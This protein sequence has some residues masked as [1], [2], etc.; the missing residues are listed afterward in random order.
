[1]KLENETIERA[2]QQRRLDLRRSPRHSVRIRALLHHAGR[3]QTTIIND[4]SVHGARVDGAIGV[5][6]G[7]VVELG[8]MGGRKISG[9]VA[10]W[11]MGV[12]GI[13]FSQPLTD[14]DPLLTAA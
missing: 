4:V 14:N 9:R 1:M 3:F 5:Y 10:W 6:P 13:E 12:C 8:L 7:D 11:L 2:P